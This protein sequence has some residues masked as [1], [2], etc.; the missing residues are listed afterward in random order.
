MSN[1]VIACL[2]GHRSV[3]RFKPDPI[4]EDTVRTLITAGTRAATAGNLQLYTF[5]VLDDKGAIRLLAEHMTPGISSPPLIIVALLDLHRVRRWLEVNGACRP[6][7]NRA[8]YFLLGYWDTIAALQ[9]VVV[10]AESLGLGTCYYGSIQGFNTQK[11][12]GTPEF[13]FPAGMVSIGYPNEDPPTRQRLPLEAVL[14]RNRYRPFAEE[15]IRRIYRDRD[16]VWET[17][18]AERKAALEAQ[19]IHG[20]AQAL[21]VQRFSAE[22]TAERS[23]GILENLKRAGFDFD[24]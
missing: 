15:D 11:H 22:V 2:L 23:H 21:A 8:V 12:F 9:N 3:R 4:P 19:G 10:A 17:V 20:I 24:A 18:S 13:V 16:A 1:P 6:V 14:H 7:L 5:L